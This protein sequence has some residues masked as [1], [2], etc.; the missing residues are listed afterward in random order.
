MGPSRIVQQTRTKTTA[1][2]TG[3]RTLKFFTRNVSG[4]VHYTMFCI[5]YTYVIIISI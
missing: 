2:F 4:S 3:E 5:Y 1:W